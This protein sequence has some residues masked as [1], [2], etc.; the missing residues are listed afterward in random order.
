MFLKRND[1]LRSIRAALAIIPLAAMASS[2]GMINEDLP[3][4]NQGARIQ[5]IY[6]YNM[7]YANAFPSQVDCLT[8]LFY[9]TDGNFVTSRTASA[10]EISAEDY[11]MTVDLPAGE[12]TIVAYGG[13]DCEKS[14]FHFTE[15]ATKAEYAQ[16][17]EDL[18]V[19]MNASAITSPVGTPLHKLFYGKAGINIQQDALNYT[20]ATVKMMRDT[21]SVRI[22][23]Q[24]I[25]GE[26][27]K[28][29]DFVYSITADNTLFNYLNDVVPTTPTVFYPY[30]RGEINVGENQ[31]GTE[32]VMAFAQFGL[33][34]FLADDKTTLTIKTVKDDK[35]VMNIPLTRYLLA[36]RDQ[37]KENIPPQEYLDRENTW[38]LIFFLDSDYRWIQV[39]IMVNDHIVRINDIEF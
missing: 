38:N 16:K 17:F 21:N 23:L 5:F 24:Q 37:Y 36:F 31:F 32:T 35:T 25:N 33:S 30:D 2:C 18:E 15:K 10:P 13:M 8:V 3:E 12:Y 26:P 1:I 20:D 7:E 4:C 29:A 22:L 14:S 27:V 39:S 9:D 6:D 19:Q 28:D 34:R 11:R